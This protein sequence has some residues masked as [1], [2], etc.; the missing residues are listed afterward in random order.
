MSP[1]S[2]AW[3]VIGVL[4]AAGAAA[5][6][7]RRARQRRLGEPV[8]RGCH[9]DLGRRVRG[10]GRQ[11]GRGHACSHP[12]DADRPAG[13]ARPAAARPR[14]APAG[15]ASRRDRQHRHPAYLRSRPPG[16]RG[17]AGTGASS[18]SAGLLSCGLLT[19]RRP[20][21]LACSPWTSSIRSPTWPSSAARSGWRSGLAAARW[22]PTSRCVRPRSA[23]SWRYR[24]EPAACILAPGRSWPGSWRSACSALAPCRLRR[25]G[26][27]R[28]GAVPG[29]TDP[30]SQHPDRDRCCRCRQPRYLR[31]CDCDLGR[32]AGRCRSS[33]APS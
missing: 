31:L 23:T 6:L 22:R 9:R 4:L 13:P 26:R 15:A 3:T 10:A 29:L 1:S 12:A 5:L 25:A 8:A 27:E 33:P 32:T 28:T 19:R 16:R 24:R 18:A 2:P 17:A 30:P 21:D 20:S 7:I 11:R 14:P